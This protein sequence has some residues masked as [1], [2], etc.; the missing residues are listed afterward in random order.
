MTMFNHSLFVWQVR[1]WM[2]AL[3]AVLVFANARHG[4]AERAGQ[5]LRI[6]E[7]QACLGATSTARAVAGPQLAA[8]KQAPA[9]GKCRQAKVVED[10][11]AARQAVGG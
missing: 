8:M 6:A 2:L 1:I 5:H 3:A 4:T 10:V 11:R 9:A 7:Q